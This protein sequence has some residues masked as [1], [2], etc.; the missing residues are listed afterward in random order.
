MVI[1]LKSLFKKKFILFSTSKIQIIYTRFVTFFSYEKNAILISLVLSNDLNLQTFLKSKSFDSN[2]FLKK[3]LKMSHLQFH[4]MQSI[5]EILHVA[6]RE[7]P[8]QNLNKLAT[9]KH[10]GNP[11]GRYYN[12]EKEICSQVVLSTPFCC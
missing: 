5:S 10:N 11:I 2:E 9:K 1:N 8:K 6:L 12:K 7:R 4:F 3:Q